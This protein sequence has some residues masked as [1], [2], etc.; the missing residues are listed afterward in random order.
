[1]KTHSYRF[2][3]AFALTALGLTLIGCQQAPPAAPATT[4]IEEVHHDHDDARKQPDRDHPRPDDSDRR[5][6]PDR[7]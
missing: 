3:S 2:L 1:M 4:V 6:H 5:D 7:P